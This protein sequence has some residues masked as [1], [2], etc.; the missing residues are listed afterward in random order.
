MIDP[1]SLVVNGSA[2]TFTQQTGSLSL[3][4]VKVGF[5]PYLNAYILTLIGYHSIF[6]HPQ[7]CE[8]R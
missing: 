5:V 7:L 2:T 8:Y 1:Y 3:G 4:A 6:D